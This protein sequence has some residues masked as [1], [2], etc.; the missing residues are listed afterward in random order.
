MKG[1]VDRARTRFGEEWQR[2]FEAM[3][4]IDLSDRTALEAAV[5]GYLRFSLESIRSQKQ[6][7]QTGKYQLTSFADA[8]EAVYFNREYMLQCYLPGL[9]LSQYL[10]PHHY[11]VRCFF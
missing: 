8:A 9:L 3:L 4:E 11:E 2:A 5:A 6:F 7:E 10:W 1:V